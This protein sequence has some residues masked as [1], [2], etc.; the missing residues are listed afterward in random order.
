[1]THPIIKSIYDLKPGMF[2]WWKNDH[3]ITPSYFWYIV[4]IDKKYNKVKTIKF[5]R[6]DNKIEIDEDDCEAIVMYTNSSFAQLI[7]YSPI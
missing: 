4:D 1:M 3:P 7:V 5:S 2:Y 6:K